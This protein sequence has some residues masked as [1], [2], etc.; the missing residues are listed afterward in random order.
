M[1]TYFLT[2]ILK[3]DKEIETKRMLLLKVEIDKMDD[4]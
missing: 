4:I 3:C 1:K 2:H